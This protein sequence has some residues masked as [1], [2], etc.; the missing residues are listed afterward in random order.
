MAFEKFHYVQDGQEF[1]LPKFKHAPVGVIRKVRSLSQG[2]QIFAVLE[3]M[4]GAEALA[5]IDSMEAWQFNKF[6][7]DWQKDSSITLGES[8]AS[9]T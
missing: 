4:A 7:E 1:T 6:T 2:E 5:A 3:A 9:A 8:T